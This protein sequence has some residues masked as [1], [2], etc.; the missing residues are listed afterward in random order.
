MIILALALICRG[1]DYEDFTL[2]QYGILVF[3]I[4]TIV[5]RPRVVP[6][7]ELF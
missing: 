3:M 6:P 7:A 1:V 4:L 2:V 5:V